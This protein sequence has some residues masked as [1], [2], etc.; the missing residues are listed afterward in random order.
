MYILATGAEFSLAWDTLPGK[1]L[2]GP[3]V[4]WLLFLDL[5]TFYLAV[6]KLL[7]RHNEENEMILSCIVIISLCAGLR[8][9]GNCFHQTVRESELWHH[10]SRGHFPEGMLNIHYNIVYHS[11]IKEINLL[12]FSYFYYI[13][14]YFS[15]CL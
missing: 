11:I 13:E 12:S 5:F 4:W 14:T 8:Y 2:L 7:I 15:Y 6:L 9:W 10:A 1:W 3:A